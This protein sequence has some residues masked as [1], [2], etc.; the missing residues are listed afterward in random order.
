MNDIDVE[1]NYILSWKNNK[2]TLYT[3]FE[4]IIKKT[5]QIMKKRIIK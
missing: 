2:A 3:A 4:N 5:Q 1:V